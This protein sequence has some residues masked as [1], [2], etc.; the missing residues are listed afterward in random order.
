MTEILFNEISGTLPMLTTVE[1]IELL[2]EQY[3]DGIRDLAH[4]THY[5]ADTFGNFS[6]ILTTHLQLLTF[7]RQLSVLCI[8]RHPTSAQIS[9]GAA[10][11]YALLYEV[12]VVADYL[13]NM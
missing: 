6:R 10:V 8:Q 9:H 3:V 11:V 12:L 5:V 1:V 2:L 7:G 13:V 4:L